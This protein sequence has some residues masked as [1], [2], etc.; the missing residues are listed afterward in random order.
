MNKSFLLL[1]AFVLPVLPLLAQNIGINED[2][3]RPNANAILDLKSGKKGL[4]IPRMDSVAR[5]AIPNTRG[6]LVYDISTDNFW[7]NTGE[8]WECISND[9]DRKKGGEAW[10]L[11]GNGNTQA[12]V[13]FLGTTNDVPLNIRV[14]NQPSGHI[15]STNENTFWGFYTGVV[16]TVGKD[17]MGIGAFALEKTLG[18]SYNTASGARAL[19]SNTTGNNNTSSGF[20]SL[21]NNITG[22][23]NTAIGVQALY[24]CT[25]ASGLTA[26]GYQALYHANVPFQG[27]EAG[28]G[29]GNTANGYQ[30]LF[31][32]TVGY[33]NTA[34]GYQ[35]LY[36]NTSGTG[37][38][39]NG[40]QA[41]YSNTSGAGNTS[42]GISSM[43]SNTTGF[44][45]TATGGNT[46]FANTTGDWNTVNG[47][48]AMASNTS[49]NE[50][51][52][53]GF[54]SLSGNTTGNG[55]TGDGRGSLA[56]NTS[57]IFNT[58][59]GYSSLYYN[60]IGNYNTAAG[61]QSLAFN[62]T[63]TQNVAN[64]YFSLYTNT[65]GS[66]NTAI[67]SNA[68]V[69]SGGL[70]NATAL[71]YGA[72]VDASN[73][74]RIGNSAVTVIEGQVPF[75]TPSDGRYKFNV[76]EDVKGLDFIL[77]LRPVT[78]QFDV[79]RFDA[80]LN[81][82][83]RNDITPANYA[84]QAGYDEATR[85]RRSGFIA[86]EVE[87]AANASG[88][89]FSGIIRPKTEQDHYSLSYDAFVV[90]LVKA[91]QEQQQI[92]LQQNKK[93]KEQDEKLISLQAQLDQLKK[94]LQPAN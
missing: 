10:L 5:N 26:T 67:G 61:A 92:L 83:T 94:L 7:Y 49:G 17:N 8:K 23:F 36:L 44:A 22:S 27:A 75:T 39:A 60:T 37:N 56:T 53:N 6:L 55:N 33:D 47:S 76:E 3:S 65:S 52:A 48:N 18:G 85:I 91:M 79:K 86:Q 40:Y 72:I 20:Q 14:H 4:L 1:V 32:T 46:L 28:E 35:S 34:A 74:V 70:S 82:A 29:F 63:G 93:L 87:Q 38:T 41:L 19:I 62:S 43:Y 88:Y 9:K 16:D 51:T 11:K 30:S 2:G 42:S 50:N 84:L 21:F 12:G 57:G 73:K 24:T 64:G 58:A 66:Q 77:Q 59:S 31:T 80:N 90:P 78:Y 71:G 69:S 54:L 13:D 68:D 45:N 25:Y 89:D 81:H 15:D